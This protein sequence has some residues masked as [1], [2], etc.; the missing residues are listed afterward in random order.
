MAFVCHVTLQDN[1]IKGSCNIIEEPIKISHH[2]VKFGC[3]R[4]SCIRDIDVFICYV[5]LQDHLI[6]ALYN[7]G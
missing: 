4:H 2:P 5:T 6:K 1:V 3:N 7:F